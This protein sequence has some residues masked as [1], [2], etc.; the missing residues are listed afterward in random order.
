MS[1]LLLLA[2]ACGR[3][4]HAPA[5]PA[6]TAGGPS[7]VSALTAVS[8]PSGLSWYVL[9]EGNGPV[10]ATDD[11][12]SVHYTGWLTNGTTFDSSHKRGKPISFALGAHRVIKGW[13]EGILG[14]K[15][16]EKRQLHIPSALGYGARGMGEVI[17]PDAD[18]VFDVELVSIAG[19]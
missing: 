9:A 14:M 10:A 2:L 17:P 6:A 15:V 4:A 18:L 13:E 19:K 5:A 3:G 7:D 8:R 16:G 11:K 12:V 1:F